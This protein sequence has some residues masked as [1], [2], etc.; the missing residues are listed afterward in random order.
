MGTTFSWRRVRGSRWEDRE[1][2]D[3]GA[4]IAAEASAIFQCDIIAMGAAN[5][6]EIADEGQSN[7]ISALQLRTRDRSFFKAL[8]IKK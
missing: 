3:A 1:Y 8:Q 7:V 6:G 2:V 5:S 4:E